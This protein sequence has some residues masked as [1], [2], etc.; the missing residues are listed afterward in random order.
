VPSC[1]SSVRSFLQRPFLPHL[2]RYLPAC[3]PA[4]AKRVGDL[5]VPWYQASVCPLLFL[6]SARY[7]F[8]LFCIRRGVMLDFCSPLLNFSFL[9]FIHVPHLV[10]AVLA[11][12]TLRYPNF[13]V[14]TIKFLPSRL[15]LYGTSSVQWSP[16]PGWSMNLDNR[17]RLSFYWLCNLSQKR[18]ECLCSVLPV[19]SPSAV[20]S[21]DVALG[22][23]YPKTFIPHPQAASLLFCFRK[24][25][26]FSDN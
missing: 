6:F 19:I 26:P 9:P 12:D 11:A 16:S 2:V 23:L 13:L 24:V 22:P 1:P 7:A 25:V 17:L 15:S 4:P 20:L 3:R 8:A 14:S 5:A 10:F 21:A 18:R